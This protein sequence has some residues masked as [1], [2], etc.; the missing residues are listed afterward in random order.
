MYQPSYYQIQIKVTICQTDSVMALN[1]EMCQ[2]EFSVWQ[3]YDKIVEN[4]FPL[5]I[6]KPNDNTAEI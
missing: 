2:I 1:S 6:C 5:H 4:L 3:A